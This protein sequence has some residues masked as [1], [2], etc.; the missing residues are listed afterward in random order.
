MRDLFS[1]PFLAA[2]V[3]LLSKVHVLIFYLLL[4][5]SSLCMM[6]WHPLELEG[7]CV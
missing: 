3:L 7:H 1:L 5:L 6:H 4:R 2:L